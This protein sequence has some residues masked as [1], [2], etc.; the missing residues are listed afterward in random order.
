MPSR[1][2]R[3]EFIRDDQMIIGVSA[4]KFCN[5][6]ILCHHFAVSPIATKK[7]SKICKNSLHMELV[8]E[9]AF[10]YQEIWS[11]FK[12]KRKNSTNAKYAKT[13]LSAVNSCCC[14]ITSKSNH[15]KSNGACIDFCL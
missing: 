7:S 15:E 12:T 9:L 8:L 5:A 13:A 3:I 11:D 6:F 10:D 1:I 2:F 14:T 4:T